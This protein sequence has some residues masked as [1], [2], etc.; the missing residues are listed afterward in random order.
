VTP[1]R[2]LAW[3]AAFVGVWF[4]AAGCASS[5]PNEVVDGWAI[6]GPIRDCTGRSNQIDCAPYVE[7]ALQAVP[8]P[9]GKT[10]VIH[11]EGVYPGNLLPT[12]GGGPIYVVEVMTDGGRRAVG[13]YCGLDVP[14]AVSDCAV[15]DPPFGKP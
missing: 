11:D 12:R 7:P 3:A 13:V 1:R 10:V 4:A 6:G 9:A 2:G 5:G 14:K 8:A 15:V